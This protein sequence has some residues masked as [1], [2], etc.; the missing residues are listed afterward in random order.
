[1]MDRRLFPSN[2][3]VAHTALAG[4][5]DAAHFCEGDIWHVNVPVTALMSS[6]VSETQHRD[7]ELVLHEGF[8]VLERGRKWAFGFAERDGYVGYVDI[9]ALG[10]LPDAPTHIV[11]TRQSY[12]T[13]APVLKNSTQMTPVS[14]GS[15]F[16]VV[17]L[18]EQDRW[19]QVILTSASEHTSRF[20][21]VPAAHLRNISKTEPDIASVAERFLGTPYHWGGNSGLGI[22]CSGLVQAACHACGLACPGDSDMQMSELGSLLP[23]QTPYERNDVL[24]W[25]GHVAIVLDAKTLVHAN[26]HHMAVAREPIDAAIDRIALQGDGPVTA[27]RRLPQL[28]EPRHE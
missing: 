12:L 17:A 6:D 11:S 26:A 22:D 18:H 19:A 24:F 4:K 28:K 27:H 9:H 23:T 16:T 10:I 5:T 15:R 14:F 7:R 13:D 3:R 25:K 1:M 20:G 21:Y 2:G 8:R